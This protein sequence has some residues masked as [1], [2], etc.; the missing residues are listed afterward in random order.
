M[1]GISK[2]QSVNIPWSQI[3]KKSHK[4]ILNVKRNTTEEKEP[5]M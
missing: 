4:R 5:D 1:F 3:K 2:E